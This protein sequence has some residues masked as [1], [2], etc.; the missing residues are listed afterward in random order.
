VQKLKSR[1][2]FTIVELLVVVVVIAIL[3]AITIVAYNGIQTK[4][5]DTIRRE[6]AAQ[7]QKA[8]SLW[9]IDTGLTPAES[10]I[11]YAGGGYG[12]LQYKPYVDPPRSMIEVF[13][14][15]QY[16]QTDFTSKI[17]RNGAYANNPDRT[18]MIATC[19]TS[20]RM[21]ALLWHLEA[22]TDQDIQQAEAVR[23][24]CTPGSASL[25]YSVYNMKTGMILTW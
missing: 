5:R 22:P 11:G 6:G 1:A 4:A 19:S 9:F 12:F 10:G 14:E 2:G 25:P 13:A 7:L 21:A 23:L 18:F 8:Y 15:R 24:A 16:I 3:A 20:T 17:P